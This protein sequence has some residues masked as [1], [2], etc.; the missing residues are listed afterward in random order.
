MPLR[1]TAWHLW[2]LPLLW[3]L[4]KT[5]FSPNSRTLLSSPLSVGL[6][7]LNFLLSWSSQWYIQ[8]HPIFT[9]SR[10]QDGNFKEGSPPDLT[11]LWYQLLMAPP[12]LLG[13]KRD[14]L[15]GIPIA[16]GQL[17]WCA[18]APS[19]HS[20]TGSWPILTG[21]QNPTSIWV[22]P[23]YIIISGALKFKKMKALERQKGRW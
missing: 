7:A 9:S 23:L 10:A 6:L 14:G 1:L 11:S 12:G 2:C 16:S 17:L 19:I 8:L 13:Q 20:A 18:G 15:F 21:K 22:S 3:M 5:T 4:P